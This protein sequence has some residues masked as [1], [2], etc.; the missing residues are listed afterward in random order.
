[1]SLP[2]SRRSFLRTL[3]LGSAAA[4]PL[5]HAGRAAA[6]DDDDMIPVRVPDDIGENEAWVDINLSHQAAVGMIGDGWTRVALMTSGKRGWDTPEGQFRIVRRVA[7]ETMTSASLGITDPND[8]YVLRDVLYTQ[9]FTLQGH[10]LHLNYW[11][12]DAVF[13]NARTSHGC[14]GLRLSDAEYFWRHLRNG[15]RVVI[16]G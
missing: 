10:A 2:R 9:Y 7:N 3:A 13:G 6:D 15:S 16:H 8:Q 1:M 5:L 12:P 11:R 14:I 4:L